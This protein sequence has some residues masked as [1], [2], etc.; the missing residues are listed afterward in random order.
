MKKAYL[1][2]TIFRVARTDKLDDKL[3]LGFRMQGEDIFERTNGKC[4]VFTF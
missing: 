2:I 3:A 4:H 1:H